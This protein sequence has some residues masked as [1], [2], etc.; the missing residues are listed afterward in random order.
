MLKADL[1]Y[2][3]GRGASSGISERSNKYGSQYHTI[4]T[5]GNIKFVEANNRNS[6]P[7]FETRTKGRVYVRVGG[8][9]L[10][11][12]IYFDDEEKRKKTIDL[13]H[14]HK[15]LLKHVHHGYYHDEDEK[16]KKKATRTDGKETRM[17]ERVTEIWNNYLRRKQQ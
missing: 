4:L 8:G 10:K 6:E 11:Q 15:G 16:S 9:V 5:S 1:Q 2:F 13:D 12:I 7:L 17:V 3:G 14:Q